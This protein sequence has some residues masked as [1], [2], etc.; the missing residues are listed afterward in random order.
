MKY[1]DFDVYNTFYVQSFNYKEMGPNEIAALMTKLQ[2][3]K[4]IKNIPVQNRLNWTSSL[5]VSRGK[6]V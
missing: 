1:G 4:N 5:T 3:T 6:Y 2:S